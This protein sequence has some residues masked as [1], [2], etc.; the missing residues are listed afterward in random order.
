M[1]KLHLDIETFSSVN[2]KKSNVYAYTESEDFEILMVSYALNDA[3]VQCFDW[4]ELPEEFFDYLDDDDVIL[5]AHNAAFERRCFARY[6]IGIPVW[7]WRCT[8]IICY[9]AG[10]PG[11]LG[12]ASLV[13]GLGEKGK[14]STGTA[15]IKM[16]SIPVKPSK[17]NGERI[18]YRREDDPEKWIQYKEYCAW[19]TEAEREL[20]HRL[21]D[22]YPSEYEWSVYQVDQNINDRGIRIDLQF[23]QNVLELRTG[24]MESL[25]ER[26][27]EITGL[28]NPNS[29]NQ[30]KKWISEELQQEV[31]SIA[32]DFVTELLADVDSPAV[33]EVL[34]CRQESGKTSTSKYQTMIDCLNRDHRIRGLFQHYGANRT[35]RWAGR[36]VQMQNLPK[37]K[38]KNG[39]H[40]ARETIRRHNFELFYSMFNPMDMLSQLVR[41]AF[42]PTTGYRFAVADFAAIEA[43]V[44]AM[45][46]GEEWKMEVF[47]THGRI[48]EASAARMFKVPMES[49]AK[50]SDMRQRGKVAELA[51]GYQ[52]GVGALKT[53]GGERL[54]LSQFEMEEIVKLWREANP[55]IVSMWKQFNK[56]AIAALKNRRLE[57]HPIS[58]VEFDGRDKRAL[59]VKLPSGRQLSYW[60]ARLKP[61]KY[62]DAITYQEMDT[63]GWVWTDTYGGKLTE[64]IVQAIARDLLAHAMLRTQEMGFPIVLHVHDELAAEVSID[65]AAED[66]DAI[67]R[68]MSSDF[69]DWA[70]GI[71]L[72]AEGFLCDYY[73][74]D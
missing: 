15:L 70:A 13:L 37:N 50:G 21:A 59:R 5:F 46:S 31:S 11:S 42:I 44:L 10:L 72:R 47:R 52:G 18:R 63:K 24:Y 35:G 39:L 66:L 26:L 19:D 74:K 58:K 56:L 2:L 55:A 48:Y 62:G 29:P 22:F 20:D 43:V 73:K 69:P 65:T 17:A 36:K 54:G 8:M 53:Q 60:N 67:L 49:I 38:S 7:R 30:L 71:P 3:P 1:N 25:D 45:I 57:V 27:K 40:D 4:D 61:G 16:F 14:L 64:N 68:M 12:H 51:L 41:A 28:E 6:G 9:Y 34:Q 23:V 33:R 32:K